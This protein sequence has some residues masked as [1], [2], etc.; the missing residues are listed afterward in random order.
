ME[1]HHFDIWAFVS[2]YILVDY[3][4]SCWIWYLVYKYEILD[5]SK[6]KEEY[7]SLHSPKEVEVEAKTNE[8][9]C[10]FLISL[11]NLKET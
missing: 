10:Y 1:N 2:H 3:K 9:M 6:K 5:V 11:E 8:L 4:Q 7:P